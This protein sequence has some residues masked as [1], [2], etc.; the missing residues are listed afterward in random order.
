MPFLIIKSCALVT[1][2]ADDRVLAFEEIHEL[3]L[4]ELKLTPEEY[5]RRFQTCRKGAESWGQLIPKLDVLLGYYLHSRQIT[6]EH[7]HSLMITDQVKQL[8]TNY[9]HVLQHGTGGWYCPDDITHVAEKLEDSRI[10][11]TQCQADL[12]KK[13]DAKHHTSGGRPE[14]TLAS[15]D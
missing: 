5:K 15:S 10:M 12:P 6:L 2:R 4:A 7:H 1:N 3:R 8:M 14:G 11:R 9:V 13:G